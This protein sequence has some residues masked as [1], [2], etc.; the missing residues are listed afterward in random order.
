VLDWGQDRIVIEEGAFMPP[1]LSR[2]LEELVVVFV[3][4]V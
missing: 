3:Y 1:N 4:V 2:R